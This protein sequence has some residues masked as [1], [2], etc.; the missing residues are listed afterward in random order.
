MS[1]C[2]ETKTPHFPARHY[3]DEMSPVVRN[4]VKK[5]SPKQKALAEKL[6]KRTQ[7]SAL[8]NKNKVALVGGDNKAESQFSAVKGQLRR[9][10]LHGRA[11]PKRVSVCVLA[12]QRI[13]ARIANSPG[14]TGPLQK[15]SGS[16]SGPLS[17]G[18]L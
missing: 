1:Y 12:A 18:L 4:A 9:Q 7:P 15:R 3:I 6:S 5:L 10:G 14:V 11:S 2:K 17:P 16:R 13:A 8:L